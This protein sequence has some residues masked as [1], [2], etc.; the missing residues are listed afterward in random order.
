MN[1]LYCELKYE[2]NAFNN[3]NFT[4]NISIN[5]LRNKFFKTCHSNGKHLYYKVA[6]LWYPA[7]N[8]PADG[9]SAKMSGRTMH[10]TNQ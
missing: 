1:T 7:S 4:E 9:I 10:P 5:H 8:N 6:T 3:I 2:T